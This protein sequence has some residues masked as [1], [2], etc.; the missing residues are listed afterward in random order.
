MYE[1]PNEVPHSYCCLLQI[2]CDE[3]SEPVQRPNF[4]ASK[5]VEAKIYKVPVEKALPPQ[6]IP[7]S[8]VKQILAGKPAT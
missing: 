4:K 2:A 5:I 3:K 1:K 8:G 6:V 7:V